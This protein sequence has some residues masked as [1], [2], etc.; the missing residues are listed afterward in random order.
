MS[1]RCM[2]LFKFESQYTKL[3][4]MIKE[5]H[6]K[7]IRKLQNQRYYYRHIQEFRLRRKEYYEITG[8]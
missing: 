1:Y 3:M 8:K 6:Q 7:N 2:K 5:Q 4:R